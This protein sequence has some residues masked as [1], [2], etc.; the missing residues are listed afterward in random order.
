MPFLKA[1]SEYV[2]KA[3][4]QRSILQKRSKNFICFSSCL[5]SF[6]HSPLLVLSIYVPRCASVCFQE[7][8]WP[9]RGT[10]GGTGVLKG[11]TERG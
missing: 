7:A 2:R 9:V 5:N 3:R 11:L 6:V 1:K 10:L 4:S 8:G